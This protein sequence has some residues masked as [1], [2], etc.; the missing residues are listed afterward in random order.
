[1]QK[2]FFNIGFFLLLICL[3]M[4]LT[5][6]FNEREP[7]KPDENTSW[8]TPTE[9]NILLDNLRKAVST[10]DLNNYKRCFESE[11]FRFTA[12]QTI[13]ANNLGLFSNWTW[14]TENQYFNNLKV[15][16]SPL[17]ANNNLNLINSRIINFSPDSLEFT[18]DYSL[19]LYHQDT[20]FAS[21][22]FSGLL[23]FQ[24]KRNRQNEWQIVVWQDNKTKPTPCWTELRQHFFAP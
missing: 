16:A 22:N 24:M 7:K 14:D 4:V 21:V 3:F 18:S 2:S 9:P 8:I 17:N 23:S 12:D 6:C 20:S 13:A 19:S 1:M 15:S 11:K 5:G 10:L